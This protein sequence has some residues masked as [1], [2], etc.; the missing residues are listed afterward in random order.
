MILSNES[1][2][3]H[4]SDALVA[5]ESSLRCLMKSFE[6]D[7]RVKMNDTK[8]FIKIGKYFND[9]QH[10]SSVIDFIV[11]LSQTNHFN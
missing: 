9:V 6:S 5:E 7:G 1:P 3:E 4:A 11:N 8:H 10:D 2:M